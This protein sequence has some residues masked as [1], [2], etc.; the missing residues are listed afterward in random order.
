M[1]L[2]LRDATS[3]AFVAR[4]ALKAAQFVMCLQMFDTPPAPTPQPP[5]PTCIYW[6][7]KPSFFREQFSENKQRRHCL[8]KHTQLIIIIII[9]WSRSHNLTHCWFQAQLMRKQM[10]LVYTVINIARIQ[11]GLLQFQLIVKVSKNA[12]VFFQN[13][14][15]F[16]FISIFIWETN[17]TLLAPAC[18]TVFC[19]GLQIP[20][21]DRFPH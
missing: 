1:L 11:K 19:F 15:L 17:K 21:L 2:E 7:I 14:F 13:N 20:R 4:L 6:G 8:F 12:R 9:L 16:L 3:Q 10:L 5:P 18:E